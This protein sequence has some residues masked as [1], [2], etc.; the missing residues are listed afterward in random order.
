MVN[1]IRGLSIQEQVSYLV[2]NA[3]SWIMNQRTIHRALAE[4]LS[5]TTLAALQGFFNRDTL[6]RVRVRR[7]PVIDNPSFY[8]AFE[9]AGESV[10]LDFDVWAAITFGDVILIS[11]TQTVGPLSHSILFHE[12]VHVVQFKIL[13]IHEFARR[14][15]SS[16]VQSGF[17]YMTI[18]LESVAFDLQGKFEKCA[19]NKFSAEEEIS[20]QLVIPGLPY[21]GRKG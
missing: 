2:D 17:N 13:G 12:L 4:P 9:D 21:A 19:E 3:T 11:E 15:V 5:E 18:P 7:V 16:F 8:S 20:S 14:Y 1:T 10:P 6:E